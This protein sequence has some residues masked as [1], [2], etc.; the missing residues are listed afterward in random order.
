MAE[1]HSPREF[2]LGIAAIKRRYAALASRLIDPSGN[3][4]LM[5]DF[6]TLSFDSGSNFG[7]PILLGHND[8]WTNSLDERNAA[9]AQLR[10][11]NTEGA[12]MC[13]HEELSVIE[14]GTAGPGFWSAVS[15]DDITAKNYSL[16]A[17]QYFEVKIEYV[18]ITPDA[19]TKKMDKH[20]ERLTTLFNEA[21]SLE[22]KIVKSMKGLRFE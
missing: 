1:S 12:G 4:G 20:K 15:Y 17:G 11:E 9:F 18:D 8:F 2:D 14:G 3:D 13:F 7:Q 21:N 22:T 6:R 5:P 19:F 10:H 16:S